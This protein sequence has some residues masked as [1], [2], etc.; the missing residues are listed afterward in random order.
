[1]AE[2]EIFEKYSAAKLASSITTTT[3]DRNA[4]LIIDFLVS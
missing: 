3:F 1:M 2:N 4:I